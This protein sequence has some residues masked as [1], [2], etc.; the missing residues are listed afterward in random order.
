MKELLLSWGPALVWMG[1]IFAFSARPSLPEGPDRAWKLGVDE[2]AHMVEYGVLACFF[3]Q[4]LSRRSQKGT[5]LRLAIVVL[6]LAYGLSDEYH[7][8]FVPGRN[9]TLVDV[10]TDGVGASGA[11]VFDWWRDRWRAARMPQRTSNAGS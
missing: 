4:G 6:C 2:I 8:T 1:V 11:M 7:Q 9:G 5:P 10:A 3:L